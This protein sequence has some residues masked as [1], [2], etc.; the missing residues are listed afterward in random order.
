MRL[1]FCLSCVSLG[2]LSKNVLKSV[3]VCV[4][5]CARGVGGL[6]K[7]DIKG[8]WLFVGVVYRRGLF[9]PAPVKLKLRNLRFN[10]LSVEKSFS[11][12]QKT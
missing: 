10:D 1:F 4:C 6:S 12:I 11:I 3:C 8:K 9:K 7:K 2:R 5:V